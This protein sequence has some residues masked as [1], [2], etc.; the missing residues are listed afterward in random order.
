MFLL[1]DIPSALFFFIQTSSS[2]RYR[3]LSFLDRSCRGQSRADL[4]KI[5]KKAKSFGEIVVAY[6]SNQLIETIIRGA[7]LILSKCSII[8]S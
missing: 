7:I 3:N 1:Y 5:Q 2:V 8:L 4:A 6:V